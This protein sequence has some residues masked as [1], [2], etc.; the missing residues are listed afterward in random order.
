MGEVRKV[1]I[2]EFAIEKIAE[3]AWFIESKN[4]PAIAKKFVDGVF[5]SLA[6]LANPLV[7]YHLIRTDSENTIPERSVTVN[8]KIF[9]GLN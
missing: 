4:S 2:T 8:Q 3:A 1:T 5:E 7:R 6:K 9:S